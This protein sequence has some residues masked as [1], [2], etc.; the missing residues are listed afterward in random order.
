MGR[1][2]QVKIN[3]RKSLLHL[4][5]N[6]FSSAEV[7]GLLD[8]QPRTVRKIYQKCKESG[9]VE[10]KSRSGRSPKTNK[11]YDRVLHRLCMGDR[12]RSAPKLAK[13]MAEATGVNVSSR[14]I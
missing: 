10:V 13:E 5:E 4:C 2:P 8:L 3:T 7:A 14:T 12:F 9:N 1:K 11:R 6:G